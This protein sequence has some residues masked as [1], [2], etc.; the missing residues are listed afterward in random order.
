M[1]FV[2]GMDMRALIVHSKM[3]FNSLA[4]MTELACR[5]DGELG[6]GVLHSWGSFC[7]MM[8][9]SRERIS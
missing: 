1:L 6:I 3:P 7:L 5:G 9:V 4:R 8:L 2:S